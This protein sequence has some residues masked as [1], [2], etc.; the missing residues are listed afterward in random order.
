MYVMTY[1]KHRL[2]TGIDGKIAKSRVDFDNYAGLQELLHRFKPDVIGIRTLVYYKDFFHRTAA[3]I[4]QWGFHVPIIAGGPYATSNYDTILQDGNI[5]LVVL[6]EG[7]VTFSLLVEKIIENNVR[8]PGE[9]VLSQIDG[10]A[11]IPGSQHEKLFSREIIMLD[12]LPGLASKKS[13][14]NPGIVN[15][16]DNLA[17]ITYTSGSTGKPKGVMTGQRNVVNLLHW[18]GKE[19]NLRQGTRLLQLTDYTF[20]P[21][22]EDIF[23]TLV[24][25][26]ALYIANKELIFDKQ[27]FHRFIEKNRIHIIDY[28][29]SVLNELLG[30]EKKLDS[31]EVVI[32]GGEPLPGEVKNRLLEKGYRLYNNYGPTEVTVDALSWEFSGQ[33]VNLG[34]P[35]ANVK[36]YIVDK[37]ANPVPLLVP[38]ELYISGAGIARGYLNHPEL[39]AEKFL[40]KG[41]HKDHLQSCNHASMQSSPHHSPQYPITPIPHYPIYRTGDLARWL[42]H[43][44]IEF[45]GRIDQQVKIRGFRIEMG[46]IESLLLKVEGVKQA[47]VLDKEYVKDE[48]CLCAYI[49]IDP[50]AVHGNIPGSD[51]LRTYLSTCL[52][53]Y[54][55]PSHFTIIDKI[56]LT[57]NGKVDRK[58]LPDPVI[59]TGDKY[60][61]PRD[62]VEKKLVE[63]WEEVLFLKAPPGAPQRKSNLQPLIGMDDHFFELGGHSLKATRLAAKIHKELNVKIALV[64]IFKNPTVRGIANFVKAAKT[65]I[66]PAVKPTEKKEYYQLS[67]AQKRL[68]ILQ[69]MEP[70]STT[71][72]IPLAVKL[73][74]YTEPGKLQAVFA[75]LIARH[76]IFRTSS[77]MIHLEPVQKIHDRVEFEISVEDE[78]NMQHFIRPFDLSRAPLMRV[79]LVKPGKEKYILMVDMHHIISDGRSHQILTDEFMALLKGEKLPPLKLRYKDYAEWQNQASRWEEIKK[80]QEYWLAQ[81]EPGIPLLNIPTDYPRP[82]LMN[83]EGSTVMFHVNQKQTEALNKMALQED[84][85]LFMV[86]LAA[87]NIM[88]AK[89]SQQEDIVIGTTVTGR[90]HEDLQNIVGM[91]VNVLPIRNSPAV[92]KTFGQFFKEVRQNVLDAYENQDFQFDDLVTLLGLKRDLNRNPLFDVIFNFQYHEEPAEQ[93]D[94]IPE[95]KSP[96][97]NPPNPGPYRLGPGGSKYDIGLGA[98]VRKNEIYLTL[99]YCSNLF[100]R[101]TAEQMS[102]HLNNILA[103]VIRDPGVKISGIEMLAEEEKYEILEKIGNKN[104]ELIMSPLGNEYSETGEAGFDF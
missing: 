20:D 61:P 73:E 48:K 21:S 92:N 70:G 36:C 11:Y 100:K 40:L 33:K 47:V 59:K 93:P 3:L 46:E 89:Y 14:E 62:K 58:A 50:G 9:H 43:Q 32:S 26:A 78:H 18:F 60:V 85:T 23:G 30:H 57:S 83:R 35:I 39:T 91:F 7:E 55:V 41:A 53:P 15:P 94:D 28:V 88:L 25:G 31:L 82:M 101:E 75:E 19:Y 103:E 81:F 69:R 66:L 98:T 68:Y 37:E 22:I 63:I 72:N 4:R 51:E 95:V 102:I 99:H 42:P 1:L 16:P 79:G 12:Q 44:G 96:A 38:G 49:V 67:S 54:M 74:E 90:K 29:P 65:D 10:I 104:L 5:D 56:P 64:E 52:P 76:E 13:G 97:P 17:Y 34:K 86:I 24:H 77:E 71:Y 45:L 80:Q 87:F 8:L 84:A 2:G 27:A 6:G